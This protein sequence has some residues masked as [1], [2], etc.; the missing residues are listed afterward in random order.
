[1]S[2]AAERI[3]REIF[4]RSLFPVRMS[5]SS[6][7]ALAG[8]MKHVDF[9][10][11][12]TIY[13]H[14]NAATTVYFIVS[15]DVE[16]QAE[17]EASWNFGERAVVGILDAVLERAYSRTAVASVPV[18][19]LALSAEA[20]FEILED[21]FE[22]TCRMLRTVSEGLHELGL[23]IGPERLFV[24][25]DVNQACVTPGN[26]PLHTVERM[27]VIRDAP[28]LRDAPVQAI[29]SLAERAHDQRW[30]VG[31]VL[32]EQGAPVGS[33][34]FVVDG[35]LELL[36]DGQPTGVVFGPSTIIGGFSVFAYDTQYYGARVR[37][38]GATLRVEVEDFMDAMEDHFD[39]ANAQFRY[40]TH[41]RIRIQSLLVAAGKP[42]D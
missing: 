37:T 26:R 25:S 33:Y 3:E 10:E 8:A 21:S 1:M 28:G 16:L 36:R 24:N 34:W 32:F 35:E 23:A 13:R 22:D 15:G 38:A 30:A 12:E 20:Y 31:D 19:A 41:E 39:L 6:A 2:E 14:G 42:I 27:M 17:G 40:L 4:T 5:D 7:T 11:G 18:R 9:A 29:V